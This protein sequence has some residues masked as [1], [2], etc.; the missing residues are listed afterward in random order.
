M[1]RE[2]SQA[3]WLAVIVVTFA[4]GLRFYGL[5]WGL[6]DSSHLYSYHPDEFLIIGAVGNIIQSSLPGFYNYPSLYIYLSALAIIVGCSALGSGAMGFELYLYAR[7]VT[8]ILGVAAV[9]MA[10]WA[11]RVFYG[12]TVG[13]IA[14]F[15][16]CVAPLHV[17]HSHFATVDVPSTVFVAAALGYAALILSRGSR[18]DYILGGIMV[19]LAA[20]TKYNAGLVF[21]SLIAAHFLREHTTWRSIRSRVLWASLGCA[22]LAFVASTP[23]ALLQRGPFSRAIL[24]EV[25]HAAAGHDLVFAGT[26][27]GFI[28][29]FTSSLWY[30]LGPGLTILFAAAVVYAVWKRDRAALVILAFVIPYYALISLSQVRFARYALPLFPAVTI[31]CGW[32]VREVWAKASAGPRPWL[33]WAWVGVCALVGLSTLVYTLALDGLFACPDPRD[34]AAYWVS[35]NIAKGSA[36]A[37]ME[38]PWFYSPPFS[39]S[40][41]SGTLPHRQEEARRTPYELIVLTGRKTPGSWTQGRSAPRWVILSDYETSDALRLRHNR[42]ISEQDRARVDHILADLNAVRKRYMQVSEFSSPLRIWGL[43]IGTTESLP[44]DMRYQSPT[45]RIYK[46]RQ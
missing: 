18:R 44:H 22:L 31:L 30:G 28:Y 13:L 5:D 23:G 32:M 37:V 43:P 2:D 36:I 45:I 27:N 40:V 6:P 33:K 3:T 19:G 24:Y 9:G 39:T 10:Y 41:G 25:R 21:L 15:V 26:G 7:V 38:V 1:A 34:R 4:A 11:G 16:L 17:Q 35:S 12:A 29:T 8:V 14:A 46:L 42:S 20:G